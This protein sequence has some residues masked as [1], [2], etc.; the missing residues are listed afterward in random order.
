MTQPLTLWPQLVL[1]KRNLPKMKPRTFRKCC[2]GSLTYTPFD[3]FISA[4]PIGPMPGDMKLQTIF[5]LPSSLASPKSTGCFTSSHSS[6]PSQPRRAHGKEKGIST[7]GFQ[8]RFVRKSPTAAIPCC[9]STRI[10]WVPMTAIS[11]LPFRKSIWDFSLIPKP[12]ARGRG[13]ARRHSER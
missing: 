2:T 7:E 9:S 5:F 13:V 11:A 3:R 6:T 4:K 10:V 12:R 1:I 8:R